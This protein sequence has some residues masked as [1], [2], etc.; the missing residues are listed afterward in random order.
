M[1]PAVLPQ[2]RPTLGEIVSARW[3]KP[4]ATALALLAGLIA[5]A[6]LLL[7]GEDDA[8][9]VVHGGA[10][11]FNLQH[12]PALERVEPRR[13]ELLRLEQRRP[14]GLFVQ[15]FSVSRVALPPFR[16]DVGGV[17]PVLAS[18]RLDDLRRAV[19]EFELVEEGKA[20]IN[21]VP[22]YTIA[23]RGRLE[24]GRRL[25][26]RVTMLPDDDDDDGGGRSGVEL[27]LEA[28]PAS[29]IGRARDVG[30]RGLTKRPYRSFRFGTERP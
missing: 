25:Y 19:P 20:R 26:G 30:V 24:R 4:A 17:L 10:P 13:G 9:T 6:A 22:G 11:A 27:R 8:T 1:A 2:H 18:R 12:A 14:G 29:G 3:G 7:A 28:T 16:G 15:S 23:Y 21:E 5:L